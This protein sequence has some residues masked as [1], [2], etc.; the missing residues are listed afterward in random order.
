M[1]RARAV[2]FLLLVAV[3]LGALTWLAVALDRR[4][5]E[6]VQHRFQALL[7]GRLGDIDEAVAARVQALERRLVE[8][9]A[10]ADLS[11]ASLRRLVRREP[12][13]SQVLVVDPD[14]VRR[15]PPLG[16]PLSTAERAFVDRVKPVVDDKELT[17]R[18]RAGSEGGAPAAA[19]GWHTRF[20]GRDVHL[21][22]RLQHAGGD[23]VA[24]EVPRERLLADIVAAL[25]E[26]R[27]PELRSRRAGA[28][29]AP[30]RVVLRDSSGRPL[31]QWGAYEPQ[32]G[33][34][35]RAETALSPPLSAW[36]LSCFT[37]AAG[38]GGAGARSF[39][40]VAGLAALGLA[41]AG[42]GVY[43][44]REYARD[45]REAEQRVS[46]V[47]QVSHEL[48]TP[49][50]SI[51]LYAELLEQRLDGDDDPASSRQLGV[52]VSESQRLSRLIDNVLTFSRAQRGRLK[53]NRRPGSIGDVIGNVLEQ[54]RPGLEAKGV[55][56]DVRG[57]VAAAAEPVL[58]DADVV[59]QIVGNLVNNVEK[60]AASG[61][62]LQVEAE[63]A[64]GT[65][66]IRVRDAGPGVPA[67]EREAIFRPFHRTDDALTSGAAGTG[68]GLAIAR[69]LAELHGGRLELGPSERGACFELT[70]D[71][72]RAAADPPSEPAP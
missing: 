33:E 51:R 27:L 2:C 43:L 7:Q 45:V 24:V 5:R 29:R 37:P 42:L 23:T 58:V 8:R 53:L 56:I 59:G 40:L 48:K 36:T 17:Y 4:E 11:A 41:L 31:Y 68:I 71:T 25:P 21:L 34:A 10:R 60:Y 30:D 69:E 54:F 64:N 6:M 14:G 16:G 70:L 72:P 67:A 15:H 28:A 63:Q 39:G 44:Y 35:A 20:L 3:P 55:R 61:G 65:S 50:T 38:L 49:L 62:L 13:A 66:R 22:Y 32:A 18:L 46:F 12:L 1:S 52:I 47:N 9:F 19:R 57:P 26:T